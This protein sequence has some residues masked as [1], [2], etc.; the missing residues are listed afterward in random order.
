MSPLSV[1]PFVLLVSGRRP[2]ASN[3]TLST[4]AGVHEPAPVNRPRAFRTLPVSGARQPTVEYKFAYHCSSTCLTLAC[5]SS[6]ATGCTLPD[7]AERGC[8]SHTW[9][10]SPPKDGDSSMRCKTAFASAPWTSW[11]L[12]PPFPPESLVVHGHG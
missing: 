8:A 10:A 4:H 5:D 11:A 6:A 9:Y 1:C 7:P 2:A 12:R 3:R